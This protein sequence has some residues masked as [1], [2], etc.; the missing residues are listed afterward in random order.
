MIEF[1]IMTK[2][3]RLAWIPS[4][5]ENSKR[6]WK[7]VPGHV[8]KRCGGINFL[9]QCNYHIKYFQG[10]PKICKDILTFFDELKS[11]YRLFLL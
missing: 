1:E 2:A 6:N 10:L 9:L 8:F 4:L 11:L 3:L 7:S 5:L